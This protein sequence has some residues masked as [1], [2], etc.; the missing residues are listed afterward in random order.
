[1]LVWDLPTRISHWVAA[2]LVLIAYVTLRLNWIG[3]HVLSGEA[4]LAL[5]LFRV[6][7]GFVG[8]ETAR[9]A[10]FI[11]SPRRAVRHL[12]RLLHR[13]PDEQI[14]HNPA[15]GWMVLVLLALMLGETLT[16]IVDN[17]DVANEGPL[18][19][20]MPAWVADLD[21]DLHAVLWDAL[22][23]AI[24]LHVAT[25]ALYAL[26]KGHNLLWPMLTGRKHLSSP[27]TPPRLASLALAL[28]VLGGSAAAAALLATFV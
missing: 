18:S 26:T 20:L 27:S 24:A 11:A 1:M 6:V 16:G 17:N 19:E 28:T 12:A 5:L 7:W 13:E 9:F 22:V 4:L 14:G 21:T 10:N 3:W 25:I 2:V 15:G 23:A 8:C